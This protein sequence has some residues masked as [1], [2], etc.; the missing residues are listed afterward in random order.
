M[1]TVVLAYEPEKGL[2]SFV[3][4]VLLA[5]PHLGST[6]RLKL[7]TPA[8][9][10]EPRALARFFASVSCNVKSVEVDEHSKDSTAAVPAVPPS[11]KQA[12]ETAGPGSANLFT[13][14]AFWLQ[15]YGLVDPF[16]SGFVF[17]TEIPLS[18]EQDF[19]ISPERLAELAPQLRTWSFDSTQFSPDELLAIQYVAIKELLSH[20]DFD[21]SLRITDTK[22]LWLLTVCRSMYKPMVQYHSYAHCSDVLQCIC[23]LIREHQEELELK[24]PQRLALAL[25]AIGHDML[26]PGFSTRLAKLADPNFHS[27]WH[28]LETYHGQV[29]RKVL[30]QLWPE[31]VDHWDYIM[32]EAIDAT[33]LAQHGRFVRSKAP[34]YISPFRLSFAHAIKISDFASCMRQNLTV[35]FNTATS[36]FSEMTVERQLVDHIEKHEPAGVFDGPLPHTTLVHKFIDMQLFFMKVFACPYFAWLSERD[37]AFDEASEFCTGVIQLLEGFQKTR[38]LPPD[39]DKLLG[40]KNDIYLA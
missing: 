8:N 10:P 23:M 3:K 35:Y 16:D 11:K 29:F 21:A 32:K 34:A 24:P 39:L 7:V 33:E 6:S 15:K 5:Y 22:L 28:S 2:N 20:V 37:P 4:R 31:M 18:L 40:Q 27:K 13:S 30:L 38:T 9:P 25:A 14:T 12:M 1:R 19:G 17:P 36:V 26:H